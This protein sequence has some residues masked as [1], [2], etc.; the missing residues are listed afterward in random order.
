LGDRI[1]W[2]FCLSVT[3]I[4]FFLVPDG[5]S[6]RKV[7]KFL[8]EKAPGLYRVAGPWSELLSHAHASYLLPETTS[9]WHDKLTECATLQKK[10]F[11]T[12]SLAVAPAETVAELDAALHRL[13]EAAG[14]GGDWSLL[15]SKLEQPSRCRSRMAQLHMLLEAAGTLPDQFQ[16]M[17]WVL[18]ADHPPIRSI[19]VYHRDGFPDLND[20]QR[21]VLTKLAGDAPA[22]DKKFERL[23]Q[24]AFKP[25]KTSKAALL[26]ARTLYQPDE[27][28]VKLSRNA[29]RV[30]CLR[31]RLEEVE[32][33][34]GIIQNAL[35]KGASAN[36]FGLL[37][38]GDGF[39]VQ[40]VES[41]FN[42][43]GVPL[44]GLERSVGQRD[45]GRE[46][47]RLML[48][49]LRRPAPIMA[50]AGLL[51]NP[52]M[53]WSLEE[54]QDYAQ[55]V[56][57]GDVLLR[58]RK[59][60]SKPKRLM[61]AVNEGAETPH[62]LQS[63]L[64]LLKELLVHDSE[65]FDHHQRA[66]ACIDQ[67]LGNLE[68]A[69][70]IQWDRLL[71]AA[72]PG[73]INLAPERVYWKEGV[74][75]FQE[76]RHPWCTVDHLI[77]LGF[78]EGHFPSG[79]RTSAVLTEQEWKHVADCGWPVETAEKAMNRQRDVF[80][81]QL[82]CC[83]KKLTIL[84]SRRD[85][86]GKTIEPSSSLVFLARRF[87]VEVDELVLELDR[88]N[89]RKR[90]TELAVASE[91]QGVPLR[92]LPIADIA[93]KTD[94]LAEFG[95]QGGGLA[96]LS[97]S[98]AETL[99][100]SPFAWLLGRLDCDRREWG[101]DALDPK[102]AGTLAHGVFEELFPAGQPLVDLKE[103][104]DRG[105]KILRQLTLQMAPFLRSPDWRVER[106]KLESEIVLAAERW[107]SLLAS[108]GAQVIGAEQWLKG[109]YNDIPL[110]GQSDLVLKLPSEE[111][112]VVD[113]KKSS[114]KERRDRMRNGFDLQAHL[115]RLMIQAGGLP[116]LETTPTDIGVIY[117]L[118]NDQT[119][120][121]DRAIAS[122]GSVPGLEIIDTDISSQAMVH[123]E[124]RIKDIRSG[125]VRLNT[126][127]DEKWW[128][129]NASITTY[130]LNNS[131][132]IKLFMHEEEVT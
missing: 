39:A 79:H 132:L 104:R 42:Q 9:I 115:Y 30:G 48:L 100:V 95:K 83:S 25:P 80:V 108:W 46:V 62:Q 64:R 73:Q 114:S 38:P 85:T 93:L 86:S 66:T 19:R 41:V 15:L 120:L 20:W 12:G 26:A 60:E 123:L 82:S 6:G 8:A 103:I 119:A 63:H 94:L 56:M 53:P 61:T 18:K 51:T 23:L 77:V 122:D 81:Q 107:R 2:R 116:D 36:S 52:L 43:C 98:A 76:G 7:R 47:V 45:I 125:R 32:V 1:Q 35:E 113:Y 74:A 99:M 21:A 129:R 65:N 59:L 72:N 44:S 126:T 91:A 29:I 127:D 54:G 50:I 34:A 4:D 71:S 11:W 27:K 90:F 78:N 131:P 22:P 112:L 3:T 16:C 5:Q 28:P 84:F 68:G 121:S 130:A 33:A 111:L 40:S 17:D 14:P 105:P 10:A 31:D 117:Y 24:E 128:D 67:I 13:V 109:H 97:P 110:R 118:L 70:E 88:Q 58:R 87:D 57:D 89:D 101:T 55:G 49:C 69:F 75:V 96:P 37:L 106:L 124:R 102:T 92:D